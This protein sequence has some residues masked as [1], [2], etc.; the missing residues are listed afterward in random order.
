MPD[1]LHYVLVNVSGCKWENIYI[2]SGAG[3][4]DLTYINSPDSAGIVFDVQQH[5]LRLPCYTLRAGLNHPN[6]YLGCDT[7][8]GCGCITGLDN[9]SQ[10]DFLFRIYPNP[11]T[12]NSLH[13]GYLLPQNKAGVFQIYDVNGKVIQKGNTK[14]SEITIN[15]SI[16]SGM[17]IKKYKN[18]TETK[19]FIK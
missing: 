17:Y 6:Y 8:L 2:T 1:L 18:G 12:S 11:V 15:K 7:T 3:T 5:A 4:I 10:H 13:I 9:L 16:T 19:K 14:S